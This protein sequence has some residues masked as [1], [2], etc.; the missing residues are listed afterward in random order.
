MT[1]QAY[2]LEDLSQ[3]KK[4]AESTIRQKV[5]FEYKLNLLE[6]LK[7]LDSISMKGTESLR[8]KQEEIYDLRAE[9]SKLYDR[10]RA[11]IMKYNIKYRVYQYSQRPMPA[12][13]S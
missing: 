12:S 9:R 8:K 3:L 2:T 4:E 11:A 6:E 7:N 1:K 10:T 13:D 5:K